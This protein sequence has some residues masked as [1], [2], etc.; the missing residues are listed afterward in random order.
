MHA[1]PRRL[2]SLG[3]LTGLGLALVAA[4][5]LAHPSFNPNALTVGESHDIDFVIPHGC[6]AGG[7]A[8]DEGEETVATNRVDIELNAEVAS[9]VAHSAE[10]W[11]TTTEGAVVS[12]LDTGGATIDPIIYPVT[13]QLSDQLATGHT[14]YLS[15]LQSCVDGSSILWQAQADEAGSP[16][17]ILKVADE[18]GEAS[19][20]DHGGGE[21]GDGE[22]S[23]DDMADGEHSMDGEATDGEA[24]DDMAEDGDVLA[25]DEVT[26]KGDDTFGLLALLVFLMLVVGLTLIIRMPDKPAS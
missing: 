7:G 5:A 26:E 17:A 20:G 25:A 11:E 13:L 19:H 14:T 10:G 23:M 21:H 12:W 16:A 6:T 8:P 9:F 18:V 1:T 22:H 3:T 4:P 15:V 2:L 24:M